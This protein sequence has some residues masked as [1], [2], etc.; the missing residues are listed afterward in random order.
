MKKPLTNFRKFLGAAAVAAALIGTTACTN[1][2][3][4]LSEDADDVVY[5]DLADVPGAYSLKASEEVRTEKEELTTTLNQKL[6]QVDERIEKVEDEAKSV[7]ASARQEYEQIIDQLDEERERLV[8]QYNSIQAATDD[9]WEDVK[10]EIK[11][12]IND[13]EQSVDNHVARLER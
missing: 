12:V 13:V 9:E 4:A 7:S 1:N 2:R 5:E 3:E 6:D 10:N 11:E 8:A